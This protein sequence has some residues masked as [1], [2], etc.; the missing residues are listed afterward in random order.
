MSTILYLELDLRTGLKKKKVET[1]QT[2]KAR[3]TLS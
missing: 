1:Q 3:R 2:M